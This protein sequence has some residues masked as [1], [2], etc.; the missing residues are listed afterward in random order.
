MNPKNLQE[1]KIRHPT[2]E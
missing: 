1:M 2:S